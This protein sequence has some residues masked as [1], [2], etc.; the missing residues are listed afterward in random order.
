MC[1]NQYTLW[2]D[3]RGIAIYSLILVW[4]SLFQNYFGNNS[5]PDPYTGKTVSN[6]LNHFTLQASCLAFCHLQYTEERRLHKS[7]PQACLYYLS[8]KNVSMI[9]EYINWLCKEPILHNTL[10]PHPFSKWLNWAEKGGGGY[11]TRTGGGT[12]ISVSSWREWQYSVARY[13]YRI[14][15]ELRYRV[16]SA[17]YF[18]SRHH[19]QQYALNEMKGVRLEIKVQVES[20]MMLKLQGVRNIF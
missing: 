16:L 17:Y 1:K 12:C 10:H 19:Q 20:Q 6:Q 2:S 18:V 5:Q 11:S 14:N 7:T 4:D 13:L 15:N 9:K 8:S 3:T